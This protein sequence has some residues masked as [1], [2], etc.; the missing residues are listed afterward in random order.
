LESYRSGGHLILKE[1]IESNSPVYVNLK[2]LLIQEKSG[3]ST[4][5][6]SYVP[7]PYVFRGDGV[8]IQCFQNLIVIDFMFDGEHFS[9]QK[10]IPDLISKIGL[11]IGCQTIS[12]C[13]KN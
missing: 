6:A 7:G 3:W 5:V 9:K 11:P 8:N 12:S 13:I 10:R 4:V 1:N 2:N